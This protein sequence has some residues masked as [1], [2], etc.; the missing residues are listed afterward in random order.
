M[1]GLN[2]GNLGK[3]RQIDG[4]FIKRLNRFAALVDID[5]KS[6]IAHVPNSGRLKE[7]LIP[8]NAVL[9]SP[10][11]N[12]E[13]KTRYTLKAVRHEG[14]WVSIDST[15][16]NDLIGE[17]LNNGKLPYFC[18]IKELRREAVYKRS[19]FDFYIYEANG[20]ECFLEVKSVTLVKHRI[21][22]F[23]DAPTERGRKHLM[24]LID[25]V[26]NGYR[27]IV[28][29]CIQRSD[30]DSFR[31]YDENDPAFGNA[32]REAW[33]SGVEICAINCKVDHGDP[34][35][36]KEVDVQLSNQPGS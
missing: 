20:R 21:A 9:I 4:V 13:R 8:D 12:P 2:R 23:P 27:A 19:R 11:E 32:L 29:F 30:A 25:A 17:A 6:E 34:V 28:I 26:K 15:V 7:L 14:I 18:R 1:E 33:K 24:E 5:G 10:A 16:V 22:M 31:P 35:L 36:F 3:Q